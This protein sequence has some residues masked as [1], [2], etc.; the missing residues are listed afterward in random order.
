MK[1]I[2]STMITLIGV[3][4][5]ACIDFSG[6]WRGECRDETGKTLRQELIIT[7]QG[8]YGLRINK[9]DFSIGQVRNV[10]NQYD[11][12]RG[13]ANETYFWNP[14]RTEL[15]HSKSAHLVHT[16]QSKHLN[17]VHTARFRIIGAQLD[18]ENK[19]TTIDLI[20]GESYS[21]T[22]RLHCSL[23]R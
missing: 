4:A 11:G 15:L 10:P 7:Q 14:S 3:Q 13:V 8:C 20:N 21:S 18:I 17:T 5:Q 12:M 16:T 6:A 23:Y 2:L 19:S 9:K 1:F 22:S